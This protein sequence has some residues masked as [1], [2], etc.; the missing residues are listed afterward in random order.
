LKKRGKLVEQQP[1]TTV[2]ITLEDQYN[3]ELAEKR[4]QRM[5]SQRPIMESKEK[6]VQMKKLPKD[7]LQHKRNSYLTQAFSS[8]AFI[9]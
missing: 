9:K 5:L 6:I 1:L 7:P 8:T 4:H 2:Q 3:K